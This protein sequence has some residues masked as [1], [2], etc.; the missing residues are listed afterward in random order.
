MSTP[1]LKQIREWLEHNQADIAITAGF[2]LVAVIAF[3]AG[4]F[5]A[6]EIIRN[7]VVIEEPT[8]SNSVNLYGNVSQPIS[9][10]AGESVINQ[11]SSQG[12]FVGS[13]NSNK[14]H[15]PWCAAAKNI[16]PENQIWFQS[17]TEARAAG[18]SPSACVA[19]QAPAGYK[20]LP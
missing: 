2:I 14:Y 5:S 18:Y 9:N 3:G 8:I 20:P 1:N 16:K 12:L 10:A 17:E 4:R 19:S 11:S 6:P 13:K 15:W 7:P